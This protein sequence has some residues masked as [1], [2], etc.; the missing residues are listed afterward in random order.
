M[1]RLSQILSSRSA[2]SQFWA[3]VIAAILLLS[4]V[5]AQYLYMRNMLEKEL[6]QHAESELRTKAILIKGM[7]NSY[8][9][10]VRDF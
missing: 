6:E 7:L 8:E 9:N 10:T 2:R 5:A 1:N 3:V 4:I